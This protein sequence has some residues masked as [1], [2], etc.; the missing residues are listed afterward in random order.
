MYK[1]S[2]AILFIG[3]YVWWGAVWGRGISGN[4]DIQFHWQHKAGHGP[5]WQHKERIMIQI[6]ANHCNSGNDECRRQSLSF[7]NQ[8]KPQPY[9]DLTHSFKYMEE[10]LGLLGFEQLKN[11]FRALKT[12]PA[13]HICPLVIICIL[14]RDTSVP[15]PKWIKAYIGRAFFFSKTK[16]DQ[17][18]FPKRQTISY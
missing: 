18:Y 2:K 8:L 4:W 9:E 12:T 6:R 15:L 11:P 7:Y 10:L 14:S 13:F 1:H 17:I 3:L 16:K 5:V